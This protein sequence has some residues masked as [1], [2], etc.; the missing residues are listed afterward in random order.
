MRGINP[1]TP[2]RREDTLIE[3]AFAGSSGV[4]LLD[5]RTLVAH[6]VRT[7]EDFIKV[8][9]D[10]DL[11]EAGLAAADALRVLDAFE[12]TSF[13]DLL[14]WYVPPAQPAAAQQ[15]T[16]APQHGWIWNFFHPA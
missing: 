4:T 7:V 15:P 8:A 13:A 14:P 11:T 9:D 16:P 10:K 2:V 6:G 5:L 12:Q 3:D 1:R